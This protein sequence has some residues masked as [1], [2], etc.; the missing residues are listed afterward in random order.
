M[1]STIDT[2]HVADRVSCS[3][4]TVAVALRGSS[5]SACGGFAPRAARATP[6]KFEACRTEVENVFIS[7]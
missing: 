7:T 2:L 6:A 5:R 3:L 4:A 1:S